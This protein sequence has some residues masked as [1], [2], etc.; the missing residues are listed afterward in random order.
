M[1]HQIQMMEL[2]N[3]G[4]ELAEFES[5][6]VT[7]LSGHV[8]RTS[9]NSNHSRAPTQINMTQIFYCSRLLYTSDSKWIIYDSTETYPLTEAFPNVPL[10]FHPNLANE[11]IASCKSCL[12]PL[13]CRTSPMLDHIPNEIASVPIC[14][15]ALYTG[16][17]G[18]L[19]ENNNIQSWY[20]PTLL[21]AASWLHQNN[22][23]FKTYDHFYN[24]GNIDGSFGYSKNLH[25]LALYTGTIGALLEN[26]NIQSWYHPTL[27]TAA[28]WLHQNNDFFKTYDHFYN[29]G[30]IDGPPL[31]FPTARI[32]STSENNI[33]SITQ[34][35]LYPTDIIVPNTNFN[36]EIH[37][38]DYRFSHLMAGY[39]IDNNDTTLPISFSDPNIEPLLFPDL[40]P[41]GQGHY[42]DFKSSHNYRPNIDTLGSYIH[43]Y[44]ECPDPQ[45]R[46]HCTYS[47][48]NIIDELQTTIPSFIHTGNTYWRQKELTLITM[49]ENFGLP[50]IFYTMTMGEGNWIHLHKILAATDNKD[51]LSTNRP[52]HFQNRGAIHTHG[53][54]W[55]D[56]PIIEL[57][58]NNI[59]RADFPDEN[60]EIELYNLVKKYQ[61]HHCNPAHCGGPPSSGSRC[62]Y[63]FPQP[64]SNSTYHNSSES[65]FTYRRIKPEDQW[66]VPYH[67]LTFIFGKVIVI[68]NLMGT[69]E[70]MLLLLGK[71]VCCSTIAV[72]YLPSSTPAHQNKAIR[73]IHQLINEQFT[74]LYYQDAIDKYFERPIGPIFDNLTY[75]IYHRKFKYISNIPAQRDFWHDMKNRIIV[76]RKKEILVRFRYLTVKNAEDFFYQQLLSLFSKWSSK[77]IGDTKNI[78]ANT[79]KKR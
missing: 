60:N 74:D 35:N 56:K 33:R 43:L 68:F 31:I 34:T 32:L 62:K 41:L 27:L 66:I 76:K 46:L 26:N 69:M 75:P 47:R 30:N 5:L 7:F 40:F 79:A 63:G 25:A 21:T 77:V 23:F 71:S 4:N 38:E 70:L 14:S 17:I 61:T 64:L 3:S 9:A 24:H 78:T 18:A 28:S 16:T 44:L 67:A 11:K 15:L 42:F 59:I 65:R 39:L 73:P 37:N 36:S 6:D 52:Y 19:L 55:L 53:L 48:N 12:N 13:T 54:A 51:I 72:N 49:V 22:D 8:T 2:D 29:H 45:F 10:C 1:T 58:V 50:Q 20:H 57:I